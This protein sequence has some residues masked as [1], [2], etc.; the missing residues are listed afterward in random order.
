MV[1]VHRFDCI[2]NTF[3]VPFQNARTEIIVSR[4]Y[5]LQPYY[6]IECVTD[7]D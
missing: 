5:Q 6:T 3:N 1:V 7:L 4:D 2:Y